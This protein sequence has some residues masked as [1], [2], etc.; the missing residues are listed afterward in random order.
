ETIIFYLYS[1]TR[2]NIQELE[3]RIKDI[4]TVQFFDYQNK[5]KFINR[6]V[7]WL[8]ILLVAILLFSDALTV[9]SKDIGLTE[10][11]RFIYNYPLTKKNKEGFIEGYEKKYNKYN[12]RF[13]PPSNFMR[14]VLKNLF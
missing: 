12:L 10:L 13:K 3:Y 6:L 11:K 9:I 7:L 14:E 2:P 1:L 8:I 4:K 5:S